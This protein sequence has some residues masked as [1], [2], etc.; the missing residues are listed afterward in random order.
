MANLDLGGDF[1]ARGRI[2]GELAHGTPEC[3]ELRRCDQVLLAVVNSQSQASLAQHSCWRKS[4]LSE[5]YPKGVGG[6]ET[7]WHVG[8]HFFARLPF[9][10]KQSRCQDISRVSR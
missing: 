2:G 9:V 10:W 1:Q 4:D 7:V 3:E 8:G 5:P 6:F